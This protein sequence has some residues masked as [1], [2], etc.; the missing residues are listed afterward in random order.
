MRFPTATLRVSARLL[1]GALIA[2]WAF[3]AWVTVR[4]GLNLAWVQSLNSRVYQPS[5]PLTDRLQAERRATMVYLGAPTPAR[6]TAMQAARTQTDEAI[7]TYERSVRHWLVGAA[8]VGTITDERITDTTNALTAMRAHRVA[9]DTGGTTRTDTMQVYTVAT[10]SFFRLYSSL[11]QLDDEDVADTVATLIEVSWSV[12]LMSQQDAFVAG[13][14][15][16]R[17][18]TPAEHQQIVEL[19]G[20]NRLLADRAVSQLNLDFQ[21]RLGD[22]YRGTTVT[23]YRNL[24][25]RL[26][27]TTSTTRLPVT[28]AEWQASSSAAR[29]AVLD[30]IHSSGDIVVAQALPVALGVMARLFVATGLGLV[31]VIMSIRAARRLVARLERLRSVAHELATERLPSVVHRLTHG[32]EVN[33]AA[34]APP[35]TS[36]NDEIGQ[37]REAFN[38]V[39]DT[40]VRLAVEQAELRQQISDMFLSIARRTQALV[41]R[42]LTQLERM[43]RNEEDAQ[44]LEDLFA[45]DHLATRMRR[46]AENLI[47]LTGANAGRMWRRDVAM[48]D[49]IRAAVAEV[50][51]YKRVTVGSVGRAALAGRAVG[52]LSHLVA[53]LVENALSFSPPDAQV[54]VTGQLVGAGYVIEIEDRGLGMTEEELAHANQQVSTEQDFRLQGDKLGLFVV[55]RLSRRHEVRVSFRESVYGGILAVVLVPPTLVRPAEPTGTTAAS[56]GQRSVELPSGDRVPAAVTAGTAPAGEPGPTPRADGPVSV[57]APETPAAES[58]GTAAREVSQQTESG[59]PVRV[60][61]RNLPPEARQVTATGGPARESADNTGSPR[62]PLSPEDTLRRMRSYQAGSRRGRAD[63]SQLDELPPA[64]ESTID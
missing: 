22:V 31:A 27:L 18:M 50:E 36:S 61:Q 26:A 5:E 16:A 51:D 11:G 9:V 47:V 49:V 1:V 10:N 56:R 55:S 57:T 37:V 38:A 6:R 20:A 43:E 30:V 52:D 33:V 58:P 24:E 7:A 54:Q 45:V 59:L 12:E 19:T 40:A 8:T 15:A 28:E 41:H 14:L 29:Q 35:L 13:V 39:Q 63:A 46:N 21:S 4:D 32:Q 62:R 3:G 64:T 25:D 2:L 34:E 17:R 42:Q 48:V 53:E 23:Q 60:R 44:R